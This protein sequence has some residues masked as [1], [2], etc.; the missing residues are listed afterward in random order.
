[1]NTIDSKSGA[2]RS[3]KSASQFTANRSS[4]DCSLVSLF[5]KINNIFDKMEFL[6][7][8]NGKEYNRINFGNYHI[9]MDYS[10]LSLF[11]LFC[12]RSDFKIYRQQLS[13][14]QLQNNFTNIKLKS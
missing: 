6:G 14:A 10:M 4:N 11:K 5:M 8:G 3:D 2:L 12:K 7:R 9:F 13:V 1:M